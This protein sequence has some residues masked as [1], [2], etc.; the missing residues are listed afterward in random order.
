MRSFSCLTTNTHETKSVGT[1]RGDFVLK[2]QNQAAAFI[3]LFWSKTFARS[4]FYYMRNSCFCWLSIN[5]NTSWTYHILLLIIFIQVTKC[6]DFQL[7]CCVWQTFL[8]F[9]FT[10]HQVRAFKTLFQGLD[11]WNRYFKGFFPTFCRLNNFSSQ[12]KCC[13]LRLRLWEQ[14]P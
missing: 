3:D 13:H 14:F 8:L 10:I 4:R 2:R 5:I 6:V 11:I 9:W 1:P 12:Q 7:F